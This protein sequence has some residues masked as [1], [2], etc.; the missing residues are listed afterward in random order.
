[1]GGYYISHVCSS[2]SLAVLSGRNL[3]QWEIKLFTQHDIAG[4]SA[5]EEGV[6]EHDWLSG[7]Q[8]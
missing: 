7:V 5:L 3:I 6:W 2:L 1:M 4:N 8:K